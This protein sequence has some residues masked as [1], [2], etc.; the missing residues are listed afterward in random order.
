MAA[1]KRPWRVFVRDIGPSYSFGHWSA[2]W[3]R[4]VALVDGSW[5]DVMYAQ[6]LV[7]DVSTPIG[8]R[9]VFTPDAPQ[10]ERQTFD[11]ESASWK[12]AETVYS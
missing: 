9:W 12:P 4:A 11:R 3:K 8:E 1:T 2:A 10:G 5:H 7:Y 6:V